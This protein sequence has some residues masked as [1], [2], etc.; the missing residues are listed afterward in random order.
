M[1]ELLPFTNK[2]DCLK[3]GGIMFS[4]QYVP[5]DIHLDGVSPC[6]VAYDDKGGHLDLS[7][8]TCGWT[9][10]MMTKD[11]EVARVRK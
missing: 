11:A 6:P 5:T 2:P 4:W 3:C 9:L 7:C 8:K 10:G 1:S